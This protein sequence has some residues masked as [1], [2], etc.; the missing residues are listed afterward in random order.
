MNKLVML[1]CG[2]SEAM[3]HYNNNAMVVGKQYR[4]LIDCGY[5]IKYA[6][7]DVGLSIADID[8]IFIT[9]VHGDHVFG[10]ERIAYESKFT[11]N[12]K[13]KLFLHSSLYEELWEQTL[14]GSMAKI[15]EGSACLEDYFDVVVLDQPSFTFDGIQYDLFTVQHT[16]G[17]PCFGMA[18]NNR[19]VYTSDT[20]AIP[21]TLATRE[22]DYCFHDVTLSDYNPVHATL[23][24]LL[25]HY[26]PEQRNK[27][28]LMSYEDHW[29]QHLDTVNREFAGFAKQG[30]EYPF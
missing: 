13:V 9:H 10:L 29:R 11:Y 18:L 30:E 25:T 28:Y 20:T 12:R 27:M 2:H 24:S 19:L 1:G 4:L 16:P 26:S 22:F 6:L 7:R 8:A 14:K 17:K 3:E 21:E 23:D 15:G 5:T